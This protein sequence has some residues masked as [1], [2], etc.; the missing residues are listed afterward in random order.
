[1]DES[2]VKYSKAQ[3]WFTN[4]D[5]KLVMVHKGWYLRNTIWDRS[6]LSLY[7]FWTLLPYSTALSFYILFLIPL[8][9]IYPHKLF[10]MQSGPSTIYLA[11]SRLIVPFAPSMYGKYFPFWESSYNKKIQ[12]L[13][14][15]PWIQILYWKHRH[16]V[17]RNRH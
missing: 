11:C 8:F 10:S 13:F 16:H 9:L 2:L 7:S 15:L 4:Y 3:E 17:Q 14:N 1:M 5:S 12:N 6:R